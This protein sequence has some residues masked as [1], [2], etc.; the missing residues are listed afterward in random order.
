MLPFTTASGDGGV[1]VCC[2]GAVFGVSRACKEPS[3][4][5]VAGVACADCVEG[6]PVAGFFGGGGISSTTEGDGWDGG[7]GTFKP[8]CGRWVVDGSVDGELSPMGAAG[9]A[10]AELG[11]PGAGSRFIAWGAMGAVGAMGV[12]GVGSAFTV[13]SVAAPVFF[14]ALMCGDV[15]AVG[16]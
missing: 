14:W 5:P 11:A 10:G 13:F 6:A 12:G 16:V 8:P 1:A 9:A 15:G 3:S 7:G 4:A 2:S